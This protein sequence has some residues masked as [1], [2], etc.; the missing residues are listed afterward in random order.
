MWTQLLRKDARQV[1]PSVSICLGVVVLIQI[2]SFLVRDVHSWI[3]N[4]DVPISMV[5]VGV[6][7]ATLATAGIL[8]GNDR[9]SR[10]MHWMS[11]LPVP[12]YQS[13]GSQFLVAGI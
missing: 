4:L 12:W 11:S 1:L 2:A 6:T 10:T 7:L 9:Q 8:F 13:L 3:P 5:F